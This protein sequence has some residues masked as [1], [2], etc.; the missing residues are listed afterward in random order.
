MVAVIDDSG[1][2]HTSWEAMTDT[3]IKH[4]E[5]LFSTIQHEDLASL[6]RI[7]NAQ[8]K[9][10]LPQECEPMEKFELVSKFLQFLRASQECATSSILINGRESYEFQIK[11]LVQQDSI[12]DKN[13]ATLERGS[14]KQED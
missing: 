12:E 3:A 4:F 9:S 1:R 2:I 11:Q 5:C 7:L 14:L 8:I 13:L 10:I 6:A